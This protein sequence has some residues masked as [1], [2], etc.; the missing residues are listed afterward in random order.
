MVVGNDALERRLDYFFGRGGDHVK[1]EPIALQVIEQLRKKA[2]IV[3]E[4]DLLT[5]LDQML[6]SDAAVFRVVQQQVRQ[7]PTLL[8][9]VHTRQPTDFPGEVR[10]ADQL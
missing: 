7:L 10:S 3:L 2:D 6:S 9:E 4:P 1:G 5:D 8:D